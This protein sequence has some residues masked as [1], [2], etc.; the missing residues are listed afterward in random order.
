MTRRQNTSERGIREFR[1]LVKGAF[2]GEAKLAKLHDAILA[3]GYLKDWGRLQGKKVA[4]IFGES[5]QAIS[6][7]TKRDANGAGHCPMNDDR[8]FNLREVIKWYIEREKHS[9]ADK[10]ANERMKKLSEGTEFA[11]FFGE[12]TPAK[13][14]LIRERIREL[15]RKNELA[16]GI[17]IE[18]WKIRER[19][20]VIGQVLRTRLEGAMKIAPNIAGIIDDAL[21][22]ADK[23]WRELAYRQNLE[24]K[25][26]AG[27]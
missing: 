17:I 24:G 23:A 13:E 12:N 11:E 6:N 2:S 25:P 10:L 26:D 27:K 8:T 5:P 20:A 7:W 1:K 9:H 14:E 22:E 21:D 16:E 4:E 19:N 18:R 15:R 3:A